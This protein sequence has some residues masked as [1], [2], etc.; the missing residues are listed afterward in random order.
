MVT[1]DPPRLVG[2]PLALVLVLTFTYFLG[3]GIT[4]PALPL[5]VVEELGRGEV[6]VG[7]VFG[8]YAVT[9]TLLRPLIGRS[10]AVHG[11]GPLLVAGGVMAALGL[12]LHPVATSVA[13]LVGAR[14]VVGIGHAAVM[15]AATT[16][17]LDLAP[18]DRRGESSSY[19]MVAIQVGMGMGPVAGEM[20]ARSVSFAAAWLAAAACTVV[21]TV[22]ALW[23][24]RP[25]LRA[26]GPITSRLHPA[27]LRSGFLLSLPLIG[28][29]GFL[30]FVPLYGPTVGVPRVGLLFVLASGTVALTRLLGARLPDRLGG[31]QT[32][33]W[34]LVLVAVAFLLMAVWTTPVGLYAATVLMGVGIGLVVPGLILNAIERTPDNEHAH[35]MAGLT[36]FIDLAAALGPT[37]LGVMAAGPGYGA[38][39]GATAAIA[40]V[41]LL[42]MNRWLGDDAPDPH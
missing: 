41:A 5:Y 29:A 28:F 23:V 1:T 11:R 30:A 13:T 38:A 34:S 40:L 37:L 9:A 24:P 6:A 3:F 25:V 7:L 36:I 17:A 32:T 15:V 31:R 2:R 42:A 26:E 21:L 14:L 19:V 18:P 10:G 20:L 12:A 16:L 27:G 8:A 4:M 35:V 39:F 33:R 22:G